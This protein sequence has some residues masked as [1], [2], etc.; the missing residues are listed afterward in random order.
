MN[1]FSKMRFNDHNLNLEH[2][3]DNKYF[4]SNIKSL[5]SSMIYKIENSYDDY[6]S[7][8]NLNKAKNDILEELIEII[9][10]YCDNIKLVEPNSEDAEIIKTN[11][12][13]AITNTKERTILAYPTEF[14][15]LYG[16]VDVMPKYFYIENSFLFKNAMQRV[17]VNGANQNVLEILSDFNG[18]SWDINLEYKNDL[19]A[20][21]IYQNLIMILGEEELENWMKQSNSRKSLLLE[22]K[23]KTKNTNY[24]SYL[25]KF[26]Y[27]LS[28]KEDRI[29]I[30]SKY[31]FKKDSKL[32]IF[33]KM[34]L[35]F[36][37]YI[38]EVASYTEDD[39]EVINLI[40][41]IRYYRELYINKTLK[42]KDIEKIEEKLDEI[43]KVIITKACK[44]EDLIIVNLDIETN[45]KIIKEI[46]NTKIIELDEINIK[47][48]YTLDK[49]IVCVYEK[50]V[51]EREIN[52][53]K[54]VNRKDIIIKLNKKHK[55]F[56]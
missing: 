5:L 50:D 13:F 38:L 9:K 1:L 32:N 20:H 47:L 8:K 54:L 15:L 42:I 43:Y 33:T 11:N 3:L 27:T 24:F 26:L 14:S 44:N 36:V 19:C 31:D 41:K 55:L 2:V 30:E 53:D 35:E 34:Q 45:Y 28:S 17:L 4:S 21:I 48:K 49:L 16:V 10:E 22:L 37:K 52:I 7:L 39:E 46:L 6:K 29:K 12:L 25:C 51:L 40:Y 23:N 56:N 18:W